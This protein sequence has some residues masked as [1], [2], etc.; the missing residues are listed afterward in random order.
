MQA[1]GATED[2][3]RPVAWIVMQEWPA[4]CQLVLEVR[5]LA[6]T[7]PRIDVVLAAD[8]K[9]DAM[10]LR[11]H[12]RGRPDLDIK[13]DDLTLLERLLLIV[14]VVGPVRLRQFLV[15]L[16]VRGAQ[17]ALPDRRVRIDRALEHDL[18]EV[19]AEDAQHG[20]NVGVAGR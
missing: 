17:P 14:R 1:G 10:A 13:L 9:P 2:R 4:A 18:L 15:E 5:Q 16:A 11:H 19:G 12:D 8:R 6:A 20:E 7:W 3:R